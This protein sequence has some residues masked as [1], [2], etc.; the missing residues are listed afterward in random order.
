MC[1]VL[2]VWSFVSGTAIFNSTLFTVI[3]ALITII[4]ITDFLFRMKLI[5]RKK[6]FKQVSN[7]FDF[8]VVLLC[9][10]LFFFMLITSNTSGVKLF[11]EVSEEL[12]FILWSIV[13]FLRILMF[14]KNQQRAHIQAKQLIEFVNI[15]DDG[16][17]QIAIEM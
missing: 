17:D 11:E 7:I 6:Y 5:G 14:F 4:I 3:E 2:V 8:I 16:P 12:C 13:Q 9:L 1:A 10:V 15:D